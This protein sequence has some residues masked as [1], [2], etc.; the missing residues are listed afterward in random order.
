MAQFLK[1]HPLGE[2]SPQSPLR[3]REFNLQEQLFEMGIGQTA[4]SQ[5]GQNPTKNMGIVKGHMQLGRP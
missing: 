3:V 5:T 2:I 4:A 1:R